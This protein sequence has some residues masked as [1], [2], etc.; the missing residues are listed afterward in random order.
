MFQNKTQTAENGHVLLKGCNVVLGHLGT[1]LWAN[2]ELVVRGVA[3]LGKD[4]AITREAR[5]RQLLPALLYLLHGPGQPLDRFPV[6]PSPCSR[7]V[8]HFPTR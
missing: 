4:Q 5:L 7:S 2:W 8:N 3:P 1:S 6:S